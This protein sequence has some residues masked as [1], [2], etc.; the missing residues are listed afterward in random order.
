MWG[1]F[2]YFVNLGRVD[3][4]TFYYKK[5]THDFFATSYILLVPLTTPS[6]TSSVSL[7]K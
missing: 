7:Y 3:L 5:S 1:S 6:H 4:G 2:G